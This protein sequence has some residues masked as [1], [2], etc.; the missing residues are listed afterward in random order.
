MAFKFRFTSTDPDP[1]NP[2]DPAAGFAAIPTCTLIS[3]VMASWLADPLGLWLG[4]KLGRQISCG[5][6]EFFRMVEMIW[7]SSAWLAKIIHDHELSFS[8]R[9]KRTHWILKLIMLRWL[10]KPFARDCTLNFFSDINHMVFQH[11][12]WA[13]VLTGNV[14]S[15][16]KDY[17]QMDQ[18]FSPKKCNLCSRFMEEFS[19]KKEPL[20]HHW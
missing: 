4:W 20:W 12:K 5:F 8:A 19:P 13:Y 2:C 17:S 6:Q 3:T 10:K 11:E 14:T 7:K 1:A 16:T 15:N 18:G 9:K